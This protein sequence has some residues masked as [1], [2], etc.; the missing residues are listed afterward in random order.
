MTMWDAKGF[1]PV[2]IFYQTV[3]TT[4]K[5]TVHISLSTTFNSFFFFFFSKNTLI[6]QR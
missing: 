6:N 3:F 1:E 2:S 5:L 4:S